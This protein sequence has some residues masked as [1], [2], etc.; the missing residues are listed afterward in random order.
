[1]FRYSFLLLKSSPSPRRAG[2]TPFDNDTLVCYTVPMSEQSVRISFKIP[3]EDYDKLELMWRSGRWP[4]RSAFIKH[5][6]MK[7]IDDG[8]FDYFQGEATPWTTTGGKDA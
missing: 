5:C 7:R 4:S 8:N 6:I 2:E 1:M 3:T